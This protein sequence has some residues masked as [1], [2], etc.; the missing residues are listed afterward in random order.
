ME[1]SLRNV[2]FLCHLFSEYSRRNIYRDTPSLCIGFW[3]PEFGKESTEFYNLVVS[4]NWTTFLVFA[5]NFGKCGQGQEAIC[6][7]GHEQNEMIILVSGTCL[8]KLINY[9]QVPETVSK[10]LNR[11]THLRKMSCSRKILSMR[12][13]R[14]CGFKMDR[15]L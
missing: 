7:Y 9:K 14:V 2:A 12:D 13:K 11:Y 10:E 5:M 8:G 3:C 1:H 15:W 4:K 6:I